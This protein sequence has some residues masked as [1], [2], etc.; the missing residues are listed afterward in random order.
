[1]E[2]DSIIMPKL[3]DLPE[4]YKDD[5]HYIR[6]AKITIKDFKSIENGEIIFNCKKTDIGI[7]SCSDIMGIYGQNG[8]GKTSVIE[9]LSILKFLLSGTSIPNQYAECIRIGCDYSRLSFTFDIQTDSLKKETVVYS[10]SLRRQEQAVGQE[11]NDDSDEFGENER[12]RFRLVVFDEILEFAGP[13]DGKNWRLAQ[14]INTDSEDYPFVPVSKYKELITQDQKIK[15]KL[16]AIREVINE[17]ESRSFIFSPELFSE[18]KDKNG[19]SD[20]YIILNNIR[21]YALEYFFVVDTKT[22]GW[23]R[24]NYMIPIFTDR[25]VL[26]I[27]D[28][29]WMSKKRYNIYSRMIS[30]INVVLSSL[31]PGLELK[32]SVVSERK[33]KKGDDGFVASLVSIRDGVEM[34]TRYESDGVRKIISILYLFSCAYNGPYTVA[35]DEFDAGIFEYLLGELLEIFEESGRGQFIFTSHNLRPLEVISNKFL[36][37]TTT[38]PKN[39]FIHFKGLGSTNNLRTKYFREIMLGSEQD[40]EIYKSSK[41]YKLKQALMKANPMEGDIDEKQ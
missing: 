17:K 37:F 13:L 18:I 30:Q 10:V 33:N 8:S 29:R 32:L 31:I 5:K 39:R 22:S 12:N 1:M 15:Y 40:E 4:N 2:N 26:I 25:G 27:K 41:R 24:L 20:F 23:I 34:P 3:I 9:A 28:T 6:I 19:Y 11:E 38:N 36:Y 35:I 7:N 14:F 16:S 21:L